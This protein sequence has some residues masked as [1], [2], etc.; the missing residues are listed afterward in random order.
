[1]MKGR[2]QLMIHDQQDVPEVLSGLGTRASG[3][4]PEEAAARMQTYGANAL[5]QKQKPTLMQKVLEQLKDPMILVLAGAAALSGA[6]REWI[7]MAIILVVVALN[8]VLGIV[9]EQKAGKALE[10]LQNMAAPYSRVR[11]GGVTARIKSGEIVPGDIV[12][13]ETGD[14]VPADMRL[15]AS[16]SLRVEEAALTGESH[17]VDKNTDA[18][19]A[20]DG[21]QTPLGSR[22]NM[23]YMGTSV[24]YGHGEG[25]VTATG[26]HTEMGKIAGILLNTKEEKTPL[27]KKL[28]AF[29]KVLSIMVLLICAAVFLL[30]VFRSGSITG[31]LVFE[32]LLTAISL[33]VAAI[34][35]GLVVVVTL[36]LSIGVTRMSARSTIIRRMTAV[37]TLGCTQVICTDKTGTLTENKMTVVE[38][39][40][41]ADLLAKAMALCTTVLQ[42]KDGYAGDPTETALVEFAGKTL[43]DFDF[44]AYAKAEE[45]PFDSGRKMMSVF[46]R[47]P[48]G[49]VIQYTKGAVDRVL[50]K[51][52][53]VLENR[54]AVELT[55]ERFAQ[56]MEKNH[57]MADN[58]L[59]VLAAAYREYGELPWDVSPE[60]VEVD[61]IFIGLAGMTDPIRPEVFDAMANCARA[62]I[63]PVMI[64]GDH[65][66]TAVAIARRLKLLDCEDQVL[67]GSQIAGMSERE[68]DE[69]ISR[70]SVYARVQP[71]HKVRIVSAWKRRGKITAMTGDGVNDAPA[72]KVADIGVGMGITGTDVTKKVADMVLADDNFASIIYAVQEGR[73]IY[74]NI[75]KA[76]QYLLSSNLAE[77]LAIFTAT[78]LGFRIFAP[79][80]ILWINLI[81]DTFPAIAL[82]REEAEADGMGK[83]PRNPA[84]SIFSDHLGAEVVAQGMIIGLLTLWSF[85]IGHAQGELTGMTMAFFTLSMS[86]IF[87]SLNLRSRTQSL[88]KIK[89]HNQSLIDA[90]LASF[91]LT[92]AAVYI[93][94]LHEIFRL[95]SLSAV[96]F[97][98][99]LGIAF[100]IVPLTELTKLLKRR[101]EKGKTLQSASN[102]PVSA[103]TRTK[104]SHCACEE[105]SNP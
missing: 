79:I 11:R 87:H 53:R 86:E 28:A 93:P 73:R 19:E 81:T 58:A 31:K 40:G 95:E 37:E 47:T 35:E 49:T 4:R 75:R 67:T 6:F 13:L 2:E 16:A 39:L 68:L 18:L 88:L 52:G 64:T 102:D 104:Q 29:S 96:N 42:T 100:L 63:K 84:D 48:S 76:I 72:M 74:E 22:T 20:L 34:P 26:M 10:A 9:Q 17:P 54:K 82:G 44:A 57:E 21:A 24:T 12:I 41:Q 43:P 5:A 98:S 94:G 55:Q 83:P 101:L 80:H 36:V 59:R 56:I 66:D 50:L 69:N 46:Y 51:C 105:R 65:R 62:G 7:D 32:S 8:T 92:L 61:M 91:L 103:K 45:T 30:S 89:G 90:M 25:V 33:A 97:L 14:A 60:S 15:I 77:I 23:A 99:A 38:T 3:L 78:L 71:E 85:L 1:M 70:I 27:Q